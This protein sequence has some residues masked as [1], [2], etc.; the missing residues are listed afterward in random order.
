MNHTL[1][2]HLITSLDKLTSL[3]GEVGEASKWIAARRPDRRSD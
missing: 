1:D 2:P 3:F